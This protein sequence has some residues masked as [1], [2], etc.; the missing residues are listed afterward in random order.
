MLGAEQ[1]RWLFE[2]PG[3]RASDVDGARPAGARRSRATRGSID[4]ATRFSMDKWDGYVAARKRL[5]ARLKETRAPNPIVLSG[6]VH[7]HYGARSEARFTRSGVRDDRRRVHEHV[8]HVRRRRRRTRRPPG[9]RS[10]ATTRT[11]SIT[12]RGAATSPAPRR[13]HRCAP[14]SR[15]STGSPSATSPSASAGR[16]SSRPDGG[17]DA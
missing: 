8:D 10:S 11:S 4:P 12:A 17:R 1:E 6:D 3:E 7:T 15:C 16:W 13:R 9:S 2:Q 5:Y 14:T